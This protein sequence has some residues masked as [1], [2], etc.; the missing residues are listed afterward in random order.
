MTNEQSIIAT[1][2]TIENK[3][4]FCVR[5]EAD[6]VALLRNNLAD[7]NA[8]VEGNGLAEFYAFFL[9]ENSKDGLERWGTYFGSPMLTTIDG[10]HLEAVPLNKITPDIVKYWKQRF[11]ETSNPLLKARYGGLVWEFEL[12]ICNTRPD[13]QSVAIAYIEN[14]L[15]CVQTGRILGLPAPREKLRRALELSAKFH[16]KAFKKTCIDTIFKFQKTIANRDHPG[17]WRVTY[18]LLVKTE[19]VSVG[20]SEYMAVLSWL[21][22]WFEKAVNPES[23]QLDINAAEVAFEPLLKEYLRQDK[24]QAVE[25]LLAKMAACYEA[26]IGVC[27][28]GEA[29]HWIEKLREFYIEARMSE[30]ANQ[31]TLRLEELGPRLIEEMKIARAEKTFSKDAIDN[32]TEQVLSIPEENFFKTVAAAFILDTEEVIANKNKRRVHISDLLSKGMYSKHGRRVATIGSQSEDER[33][34]EILELQMQMTISAGIL[35]FIFKTGRERNILTLESF[36]EYIK[37]SS[38]ISINR[39]PIFEQAFQSWLNGNYLVFIH[40]IV[41]QIEA[42]CL[43]LAKYSSIPIQ[44]ENKHGGYNVL[45]FGDLLR[46]DAISAKIGRDAIAYFVTL[47]SD[48]RG[49]NLRNEV[50][51]GLR[52]TEGF[53]ENIS[54]LTLIALLYLV[55]CTSE[56]VEVNVEMAKSGCG[57]KQTSVGI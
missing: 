39:Y 44:R 57:D 27:S 32:F 5:S 52:D 47:F 36:M 21:E 20:T 1:L 28:A 55:S 43:L 25:V 29:M 12:K 8:V 19:A 50:A 35:H 4:D 9:I 51:H 22:E 3:P 53:D 33:G 2:K 24:T 14:L 10:E 7:K 41:P 18:D 37:S 26:R 54:N 48:P 49:F 40:L 6:I 45:L 56:S 46:Q 34:R 31:L 23:G 16:Q 38:L 13:F 42:A 17:T 30:K 11:F 15:I